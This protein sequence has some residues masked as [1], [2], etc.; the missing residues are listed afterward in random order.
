MVAM[1]ETIALLIRQSY[2]ISTKF[3]DDSSNLHLS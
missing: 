2:K 1:G 3:N